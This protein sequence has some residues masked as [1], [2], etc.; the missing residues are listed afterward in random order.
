[1]DN[2]IKIA[3]RASVLA[4]IQAKLV[5]ER[6]S[7]KHPNY[8]IE[9]HW[10][11]TTGDL[12]QRLDISSGSTVGVFT[13]DIS[14]RI[15]SSEFDMAIHSWK[16][17]P[18]ADNGKSKIYGT[19]E[20][21]DLRDVLLLKNNLKTLESK[22]RIQIMTSS[23]RRRYSLEQNLI[24][25]V[26]IKFNKINFL[27]L[28]GNID[29]RLKKFINDQNT[30]GIVIAKAALDRVIQTD[31]QE[32]QSLK[33]I[34]FKCLKESHW[35][36]LPLSSFP[37]AP[38]QGAIGIEVANKNKKI[39]EIVEMINNK[40]I[41]KNVTKEK[42]I[43]SNYGG[44]CSQKI[45]VSIWNKNE[46]LVH[47]L[48]GITDNKDKLKVYDATINKEKKT[49]NIKVRKDDIFPKNKEEQNIFKRSDIDKNDI[50]NGLKNTLIYITRKNVL[51][52]RPV[53][54]PS[55]ILWTSGMKSWKAANNLGY[56]IHGSSDSMGESEINSTQTFLGENFPI[57][58]LTFK[59]DD[60]PTE[61]VINVYELNN[62]K[63]PDDMADRK[64]FFWMS[65]L[66]FKTALKQYPEIIDK[67]HACGMGN[68]YKKLK[69]IIT[70][71]EKL[72][73]HISYESWLDNLENET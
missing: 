47:S 5:G 15:I 43:M 50:L 35:I 34:I 46:N 45:G 11:K 16:D 19:L 31:M 1:M 57:T 72:D 8:E 20:R 23:P 39:I 41:H 7:Q 62:P 27:D 44:G 10:I 3:S 42:L 37:T 60:P 65:T 68:T 64:E 67:Q 52:N 13:S 4:K 33:E 55:C 22:E 73:C 54:D 38:G 63:F 24:E 17:Y 70:N 9:Y 71:E 69:K 51:N 56:W 25:L 59:N 49:R 36:V 61:R 30:D 2:C 14:Q 21:A 6:I 32:A 40:T 48:F 53:F 26:P 28:R 66:A 29:T 18:I 58:K 12:D